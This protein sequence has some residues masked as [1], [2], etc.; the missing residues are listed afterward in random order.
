MF[1]VSAD[2]EGEDDHAGENSDM[3]LQDY[4]EVEVSEEGENLE[5]GLTDDWVVVK[6]RQEKQSRKLH[7]VAEEGGAVMKE[8]LAGKRATRRKGPV[9]KG[10][11]T[12]KKVFIQ[13]DV[14]NKLGFMMEPANQVRGE[15]NVVGASTPNTL[16]FPN[17]ASDSTTKTA[18]TVE[19][20]VGR[21][22]RRWW[23]T[24]RWRRLK[25]L[26]SWIKR[27]GARWWERRRPVVTEM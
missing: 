1:Q 6:G 13:D 20:S 23:W 25:E 26:C 2:G 19:P 18:G 10:L 3:E 21:N 14:V 24:W 4:E 27:G 17:G 8:R 7:K 11:L 12:K 5:G 15:L 22:Q 9:K 16:G